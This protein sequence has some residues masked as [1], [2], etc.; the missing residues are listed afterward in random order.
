MHR[1]PEGAQASL[2]RIEQTFLDATVSI[3]AL[4]EAARKIAPAI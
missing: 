1:A 4:D 2:D 3:R